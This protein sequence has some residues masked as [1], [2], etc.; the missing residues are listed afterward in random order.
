[1]NYLQLYCIDVRRD[2]FMLRGVVRCW[3]VAAMTKPKSPEDG[4]TLD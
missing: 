2:R 1:M 3:A 4:V